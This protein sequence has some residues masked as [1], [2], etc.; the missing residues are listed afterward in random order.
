[1]KTSLPFH[2]LALAL[3]AAALGAA[4]PALAQ[5]YPSR[6]IN[7]VVGY[8]AGGSVDLTARVLGEELSE[9]LNQSVV[10]ENLGGAG[11][12]IG[13]QRVARAAA[14][15]YTLLV[16]S[17]NEM[18]IAGMINNAV[19]YDGAKD[20]TP[21]GMIAAQPL[22]LTASAK[23]GVKT[24]QE[25]LDKLK[26]AAPG[27]YNYGSSGIGTSLHLAGE[28]INESTG[29]KAEHI[30]Y[31]GVGPL[32]TDLINGQLDF[33]VL[34]MSS[35]LPQVKGGKIVAL[36]VTEPQRSAVAPDIPALAETP[37]FEKVDINVWFGLYG[38]AGLPE[39]VVQ[40]LRTALDETLQSESFRKKMAES[41]ATVYEPGLDAAAFQAAET[42]KY[43][44]LVKMAGIEKH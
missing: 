37:G 26:A 39:P 13:A 10:V 17:A 27:Q 35:G 15:G 4:A 23:S 21:V 8:P 20:F 32:V 22:L 31:R 18:V 19:R 36:G 6:A 25:Y 42:E 30:P 33:G 14:D 44:R 28:M 2:R 24:A 12:T 41:G 7:L 1:M 16:G 40:R 11:G 38:P 43:E 34:V 29:T 9:R 3:A 5:D